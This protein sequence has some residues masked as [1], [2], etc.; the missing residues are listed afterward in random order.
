MACYRREAGGIVLAVRLTPKAARDAI[1]GRAYLSDGSEVAVARVRAVPEKG[2][3]NKALTDLL[4]RHFGVAKS[5]VAVIAG[6]SGRLKQVRIAGSAPD[7]AAIADALP[8]K[9]G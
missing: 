7:L 9:T 1:D 3:A 4:A 6:G 5:A 2:A 8:M